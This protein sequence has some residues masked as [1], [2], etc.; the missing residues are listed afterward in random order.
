M[1]QASMG[2]RQA[3]SDLRVD[4]G[5]DG[6]LL[7]E[8]LVVAIGGCEPHSLVAVTAMLDTDGVGYQ[9]KAIFLA[10]QSGS[11]DTGRQPSVDGSYAGIDPFGLAWSS[12]PSGRS[13]APTPPPVPMRCRV[14]VESGDV[15]ATAEFERHWLAPGATVVEVREHGIQGIFARPAGRGPFPGLVA[16]GGS[17]GGL[18]PT[19]TWAP[20]L[21]SHGLDLREQPC[22]RQRFLFV[23]VANGP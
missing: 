21:A 1:K 10:D 3:A 19:A 8:P 13:A 16:F 12:E 5:G 22:D 4:V 11:V 20:V 15:A 6:V 23:A 9:S 7:D 14:R 18:G 2:A 17:G